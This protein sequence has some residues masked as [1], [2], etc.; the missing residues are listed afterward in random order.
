MTTAQI[1]QM[2]EE[3]MYEM[4]K[5]RPR[6]SYD[7][8]LS[9][10]FVAHCIDNVT[11]YPLEKLR[12][13][14][15]MK[16]FTT[17]LH[18]ESEKHIILLATYFLPANYTIPDQVIKDFVSYPTDVFHEKHPKMSQNALFDKALHDKDYHISLT[19]V[20]TSNQPLE[21]RSWA[22]LNEF[23]KNLD[24]SYLCRITARYLDL[25]NIKT[26]Y[27]YAQ[28]I[29]AYAQALETEMENE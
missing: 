22:M 19:L 26:F 12:F 24:T 25:E 9:S 18:C 15:P 20:T 8:F 17:M 3:E 13:V 10:W 1:Y 11:D 27:T 5:E 4:H 14:C 23:N 21:G 16:F 7:V 28:D 29:D 2:I 6:V